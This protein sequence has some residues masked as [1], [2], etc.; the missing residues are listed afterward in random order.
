MAA[1]IRF[2][3]RHAEAARGWVA[4]GGGFSGWRVATA[5]RVARQGKGGGVVRS[6]RGICGIQ[7]AY[8]CIADPLAVVAATVVAVARGKGIAA[9]SHAAPL[10][11]A[12]ARD[13]AR[14]RS[15]VTT[16][17]RARLVVAAVIATAPENPAVGSSP[18]E[19]SMQAAGD[20]AA[21]ERPVAKPTPAQCT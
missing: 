18:V 20:T 4:Q 5:A 16:V 14:Q 6:S 21:P 9:A 15:S 3:V 12:A 11:A 19:Y 2:P 1:A 17:A 8:S 10:T 13:M 7:L